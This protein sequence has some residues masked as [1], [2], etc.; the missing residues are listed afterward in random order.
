MQRPSSL[1][2]NSLV[3]ITQ[4]S[5]N[6]LGPSLAVGRL[7]IDAERIGSGSDTKGKAV[8]V[9]HTWKDHLWG[10]GSKGDPPEAIPAPVIVPT[11]DSA[12]WL[13]G[14]SSSPPEPCPDPVHVPSGGDTPE[15]EVVVRPT[16]S[17][18]P[19]HAKSE[20]LTPEGTITV[21]SSMPLP[22]P[23]SRRVVH[24]PNISSPSPQD[25]SGITPLIGL[26]HASFR[27]L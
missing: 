3:S 8:A 18:T 12:D 20:T 5:R 25:F 6:A 26:P 22:H 13:A 4:Y 1:Q 10:M 23:I 19:D 15:N 14:E 24:H 27:F 17:P 21:A 16:G 2:A 11:A 9:L 7:F